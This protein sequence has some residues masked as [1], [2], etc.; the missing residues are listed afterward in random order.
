MKYSLRSLFVVVTL[1]GVVLGARLEYLRRWA[2][3]HDRE[4]DWYLRKIEAEH[5]RFL[6]A[7][8][9]YREFKSLTS[10]E[11]QISFLGNLRFT[12][13]YDREEE[14]RVSE[15]SVNLFQHHLRSIAYKKAMHSPWRSVELKLPEN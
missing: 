14:S 3:F 4:V 5:G 2:A 8:G 7:H 9:V 10:K 12:P 15:D 13:G 6:T 11:E 1:I